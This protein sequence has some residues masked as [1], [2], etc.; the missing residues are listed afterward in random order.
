M[1]PDQGG[2]EVDDDDDDNEDGAEEVK[3]FL[4]R[5]SD[6]NTLTGKINSSGI[7]EFDWARVPAAVG[8]KTDKSH[9]FLKRNEA[10]LQQEFLEAHVGWSSYQYRGVGQ[11]SSTGLHTV[12]SWGLWVMIAFL[13]LRKQ[14][15]AKTKTN[16]LQLLKSLVEVCLSLATSKLEF[17]GLIFGTDFDYHNSH[18]AFSNGSTDDLAGL[19]S[20]HSDAAGMWEFLCKNVWCDCKITSSL[21]H[22]TLF[23][24]L[25][26]LLYAKCH[27]KKFAKAMWRDIG[28]FMWPKV[29]FV[30]GKALEESAHILSDRKPEAAPLLKTKAGGNRRV[31]L[32]NKLLLLNKVKFNKSHRKLIMSSH[33]D[34]V[35]SG[36][37]LVSNEPLVECSL[38]IKEL[39]QTFRNCKHLQVSW[40]PSTY[41]GEEVLVST[42]WSN[43][44]HKAGYLPIQCMLPIS[45]TE[46]DEEYQRLSLKRKVTRVDGFAEL[47]AL[48]H[49]L[50]QIGKPLELFFVDKRVLWAPLKADETRVLLD[51]S[52]WVFNKTTKKLQ[53]QVPPDYNFTLQHCLTSVSDQGAI[54]KSALDYLQHY[55]KMMVVVLYDSHHRTWNDVKASLRFAK[56]FKV[57]LSFAMLFNINYG[58][59]NSKTWFYRKQK[60]LDEFKHF[61]SQDS[62][63]FLAFLPMMLAE[64]FIVEDGT[65]EQKERMFKDFLGM[66]TC[67]ICGPLTKLMRWW[68]WWDCSRFFSGEIWMTK[69]LMTSSIDPE[70]DSVDSQPFQLPDDQ[71]GKLTPQQE[72]RQLKIKHGGWALAPSLVTEQAMWQRAL[73][74]EV[75]QPLWSM[76]SAMSKEVQKPGDVL[77]FTAQMS[78]QGWVKELADLI[79]HGFFDI[80][81][82]KRLYF[83]EASVNDANI[84]Q[85][86]KFLIC[87]L[88]KRAMSL[89]AAYR[90]PPCRYAGLGLPG[91]EAETRQAMAQEWQVVLEAE[92]LVAHGKSV[93]PLDYIHCLRTSFVRMM[94]LANER[95]CMHNLQGHEAMAVLLCQSACQHLGDTVVIEN[96]HQKT[97]DLLRSARHKMTGRLG[98]FHAVI[99]SNVLKGRGI[100][101]VTVD[102]FK[103]ANASV[104]RGNTMQVVKTTHP[105]G[106]AMQKQFQD[107]MKY[108]ASSPGFNWP[109]SSHESLFYEGACLEM[110]VSGGFLDLVRADAV[111]PAPLTCPIGKPGSIVANQIEGMVFLVIALGPL[112]F[113]A[114]HLSVFDKD[115]NNLLSLEV[116]KGV[117]AFSWQ[118]VDDLADWLAVP[119]KGALRNRFGPLVFQQVSDAVPLPEARIAEGL[120]LT[121]AQCQVVLRQFGQVPVSKKKADLYKQII[122]LFVDGA[123]EQKKALDMSDL[124]KPKVTE[125]DS[126]LSE[127]EDLLDHVEDAGN[128]ADPDIKQERQ[129][130][131][132]AKQ[133][134]KT[135][136]LAN[137]AQDDMLK[138]GRGRGRGKGRGKGV[139]GKF[140]RKPGR[141]RGRGRGSGTSATP[142]PPV[143]EEPG[144]MSSEVPDAAAESSSKDLGDEQMA[145]QATQPEASQV[146]PVPE[147]SQPEVPEA[148]EADTVPGAASSSKSSKVVASAPKVNES[149]HHLL[150]RLAPPTTKMTLN[151]VEHRWVVTFK[152]A[153][154][155]KDW[156]VPPWAQGSF[157]KSFTS[158]NWLQQLEEVHRYAWQKWKLASKER[159]FALKKGTIE[160][161]PG[162]MDRLVIKELQE[163]VKNLPPVFKKARK[164]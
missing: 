89:V 25:F 76:Y 72:L 100:D 130:V 15:L 87:L 124:T 136:Q 55:L 133:K 38:Y 143:P 50:V 162:K 116:C 99:T 79:D 49:A 142:A 34:L 118:P 62:Q 2:E 125:D 161:L 132:L 21:E 82:M 131:K 81:V 80:G 47:R 28:S 155:T 93:P 8:M 14:T 149:P 158:E 134:K 42:V 75:G 96:T 159:A 85:H 137:S 65:P 66:R 164:A 126:D 6:G 94:F 84:E 135:Q 90:S 91:F 98:K 61:K 54:N 56:L 104:G 37:G 128:L 4:F 22:A 105:N 153:A 138:P 30:L 123:E 45:T 11:G 20:F 119:A 64:R 108:K 74:Y 36:V 129:K 69:L 150:D 144:L 88:N 109:S 146:A 63:N 3:P 140:G 29:V 156:Q 7:A 5:F 26:F 58:P 39:Q 73:I 48:A 59:A 17:D 148:A 151:V 1:P 110:L 10:A 51:G 141:G 112:N 27:Q 121:V 102:D 18:V 163:V 12:E 115:E 68:S 86:M 122:E 19:F 52:F 16:A 154:R 77:A 60:V 97:K 111:P 44:C 147:A 92:H 46:V 160:Q 101:H 152:L 32:V 57:F 31:P 35:P 157:S 113:L 95:D 106:H 103:K 78:K 139:K 71:A 24:I 117:H 13:P 67:Q 23:D 127:L 83:T 107:L 43:E 53:Q 114:W 33:G 40:D 120:S 70:G 9:P 41:N 145:D